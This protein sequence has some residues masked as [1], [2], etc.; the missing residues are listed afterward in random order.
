MGRNSAPEQPGS[1]FSPAALRFTPSA[2]Q[3]QVRPGLTALRAGG[4]WVEEKSFL[5]FTLWA[6][7]FPGTPCQT[8]PRAERDAWHGWRRGCPWAVGAGGVS[9]LGTAGGSWWPRLG[10]RDS[11]A[12]P[13]AGAPDPYN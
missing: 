13:G 5:F 7:P 8:R 10:D 3:G 11:R 6:S 12:Q 1:I 9:V 2:C 4:T